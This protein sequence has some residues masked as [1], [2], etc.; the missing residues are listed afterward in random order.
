MSYLKGKKHGIDW[1]EGPARAKKENKP[2][3]QW[4]SKDD[5]NYAASKAQGLKKSDGFK[6]FSL[7]DNHNSIV[8]YPDGSTQKATHFRIRNNDTG[9]FHGYPIVKGDNNGL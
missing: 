7:P 6:D 8:H 2:Q 1:K 4:G 9:T 5:L 3:G